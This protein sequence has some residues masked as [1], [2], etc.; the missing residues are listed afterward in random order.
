MSIPQN[1]V[2]ASD[3]RIAIPAETPG[4]SHLAVE[5]CAE[6]QQEA[7]VAQP[8]VFAFARR[9]ADEVEQAEQ[10]SYAVELSRVEV[11]GLDA[12]EEVGA[13]Q[14]VDKKVCEARHS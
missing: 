5:V 1:D 6:G 13:A 12:E 4:Q 10:G 9:K 11:L 8:S 14:Q 7:A 2:P 3:E